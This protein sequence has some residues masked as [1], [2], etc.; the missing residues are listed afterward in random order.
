MIIPK[1]FE[2][3]AL[4]CVKAPGQL[5]KHFRYSFLLMSQ[6]LF[7]LIQN[8]LHRQMHS[9][10]FFFFDWRGLSASHLEFPL[11]IGLDF[12]LWELQSRRSVAARAPHF[13]ARR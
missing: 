10:R 7:L 9:C 2:K 3:L 8:Q 6:F 1:V 13:F 4:G 12:L 11:K 5:L